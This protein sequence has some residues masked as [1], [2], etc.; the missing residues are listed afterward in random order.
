[1]YSLKNLG[2]TIVC[3]SLKSQQVVK[4]SMEVVLIPCMDLYCPN[5]L[6][7]WSLKCTAEW[8][9]VSAGIACSMLQNI[10]I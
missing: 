10:K 8:P 1:M 7:S 4:W 3:T 9:V 2:A 6:L 5:R